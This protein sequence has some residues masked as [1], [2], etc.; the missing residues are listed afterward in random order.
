MRLWCSRPRSPIQELRIAPGR[1]CLGCKQHSILNKQ[2]FRGRLLLDRAK[3][4][5][6]H[7]LR[8]TYHRSAGRLGRPESTQTN[9]VFA[10]VRGRLA[11][12]ARGPTSV[13][14]EANRID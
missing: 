7:Q 8:G 13:T 14:S 5:H 9:R 10:G 3:G 2:Q 6:C 1:P 11:R 12:M 4:S